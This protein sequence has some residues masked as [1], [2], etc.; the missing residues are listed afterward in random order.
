MSHAILYV[1]APTVKE[2]EAIAGKLVE[3][4]LA[5]CA[6]VSGGMRSFF[7]WEDKLQNDDE[8]S[9]ILKTKKSLIAKATER[10]QELHSYDCP[11]VIALPII[12]GSE[13]FLQWID[14]ETV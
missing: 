10:I 8:V 9:F 12:G 13:A 5:A 14:E 2:A 7:R 4:K 11:C 6:N 1:T 3:E